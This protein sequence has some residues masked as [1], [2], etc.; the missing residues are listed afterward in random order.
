VLGRNA[1]EP[2]K[3]VH[4]ARAGLDWSDT[5]DADGCQGS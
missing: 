4:E 5:G 2:Q 3:M 1:G